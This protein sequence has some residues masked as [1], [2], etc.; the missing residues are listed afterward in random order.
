MLAHPKTIIVSLWSNIFRILSCISVFWLLRKFIPRIRGSYLF[1]DFWVLFNT[2]GAMV[3][4]II[5]TWRIHQPITW[6]FIFI[7]IYGFLRVFEIFVYQVNVLLFDEYR[8]KKQGK[9][10]RLRGYRRI[11]LL[12]IH[13]YIEIILWFAVAYIFATRSH[14]IKIEEETLLSVMRESLLVMVTFSGATLKYEKPEGL[15]ILLTQSG[16]GIF[17]TILVLAR[18]I[19]LLPSPETMDEY[20][21]EKSAAKEEASPKDN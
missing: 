10:Y 8:A 14:L 20:E 19:S 11:I 2:L 15:L 18:F 3:V 1:V 6:L 9:K 5:V 7:M 17:M 13:N 16:I 4:L 21:I 12:L